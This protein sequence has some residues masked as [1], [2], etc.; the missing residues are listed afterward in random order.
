MSRQYGD[1]LQ[2]TNCGKD[3]SFLKINMANLVRIVSSQRH[4]TST[5]DISV[6]TVN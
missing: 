2:Y 5:P 3:M 6:V 4:L 1:V